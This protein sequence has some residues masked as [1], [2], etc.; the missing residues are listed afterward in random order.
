[1]L[2]GGYFSSSPPLPSS[3][4]QFSVSACLP[5]PF[6]LFSF[7][8]LL[9]PSS[10]VLLPRLCWVAL[11]MVR[12]S[13]VVVSLIQLSWQTSPQGQRAHFLKSALSH[14]GTWF[15]FRLKPVGTLKSYLW[16][17]GSPSSLWHEGIS[18]CQA[19]QLQTHNCTQ[20]HTHS[21]VMVKAEFWFI[22]R[23]KSV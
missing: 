1:M 13:T 14:S 3:P 10:F 8:F 22:N 18:Y 17:E 9:F 7:L 6:P 11:C 4:L 5:T 20:A 16:A 15:A 12:G 21:W 2:V 23:L 19:E